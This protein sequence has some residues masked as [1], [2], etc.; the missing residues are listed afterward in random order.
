MAES[1]FKAALRLGYIDEVQKEKAEKYKIETGLSEDSVIRDTKIISDE[2]IVKLYSDVYHIPIG[3]IKEIKDTSLM[4]RLNPKDMHR[5]FF[6]PVKEKEDIVIYTSLP[7]NLLYAED[8]LKETFGFKGS[9]IH[10]LISHKGLNT[11]IAKVFEGTGEVLEDFDIEGEDILNNSVYDIAEEDSSAVVNLINK[12][13]RDAISK[14]TSDVHFEPQSDELIIRFREDGTLYEYMKLPLSVS[15]QV[16]NR[17]K[18]MSA[19][20]VNISKTIQD[21]NCRLEIF[22]KTVDL[23]ISV[24]P[25]VNGENIVIR[26]LDQN[27]MSLDISMLGFSKENE[28]LFKKLIR[29]PQGM[30]LLT[31]PTGS[32]KSTSLYAAVSEL[33]TKD[34]CIIT[35]EDPVEYRVPGI[36]QVQI[37]HSM[38]V[39]FPQALK[40]GLRQDIEVALVGEIRDE[41]TASI[42]FDAA[43]TGHMVFSTLHTNSAASSI[44]RLTKMGIEPYIIS[45][46]LVAV[47]N[48]RLVKRICENCKEEYFLE[49]NSPYR[50]IL[51]C[52][53]HPMTMFRGKGCSECNGTGYKGR[54][55]VQ[56]FLV[57]N[58]EIEEL[59]DKGASTHEIEL[60]AIKNGMK[61]IHTDGIEKAI[62]GITTLDEIHRCV[63]FDEL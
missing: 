42:A 31:G 39:T 1:I 28:E 33:N 58:E 18:T 2:A 48:Q 45:R 62:K 53:S 47:I 60:A 23:R 38:N 6:F 26:I 4:Q 34:R 35:F 61:K 36:V 25:A 43:N 7:S 30:I 24:I 8:L 15:R 54:V 29:R 49:E 10:K 41:E 16:L 5:L 14:K 56:E 12:I 17:I 9:F 51:G 37:N 20:D 52:G 13:L 50:K 46:S 21:G 19:L 22:G 11:Y 40:S 3:E 32:G 55:A 44:I 27:K 59:L 57:L 63:F